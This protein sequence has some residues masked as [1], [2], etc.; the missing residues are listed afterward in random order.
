M[1][2]IL[3]ALKKLETEPPSS[4]SERF[5]SMGK[6]TRSRWFAGRTRSRFR[7]VWV[8]VFIL[9]FSVS[10]GGFLWFQK[11]HIVEQFLSGKLQSS[12]DIGREGPKIVR[13]VPSSAPKPP[14][15]T[16][17]VEILSSKQKGQQ[18]EPTTATQKVSQPLKKSIPAATR[19]KQSQVPVTVKNLPLPPVLPEKVATQLPSDVARNPIV[20]PSPPKL[21]DSRYTLQAIAWSQNPE[22]RL[23]VINGSVLRE[24]DGIEGITV[25]QIGTNEVIVKK[26]ANLWKLVFQAR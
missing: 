18:K 17:K 14:R 8:F 16:V 23:A 12:T 7:I 9:V 2:I 21:A 19:S 15:K 1:S 11:P 10:A 22:E 3:N 26:D 20:S 5:P 24:G 4:D 13:K 6:Q 25:T